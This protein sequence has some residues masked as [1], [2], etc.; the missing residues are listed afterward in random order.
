MHYVSKRQGFLSSPGHRLKAS[1][2]TVLITDIPR[3]LC[4]VEALAALYDDFPGGIRRIW[5]NRNFE[6]LVQKEAAR[7]TF[8]TFLEDAETNLVRR[9]VKQ[10]RKMA[11]RKDQATQTKRNSTSEEGRK[12]CFGNDRNVALGVDPES[13]LGRATGQTANI[14]PADIGAC[15][16]DLGYDLE[17]KAAWTS[18]CHPKQRQKMRIPKGNH[19]SAFKI[20]LIGRLFSAKVDTIYYCRRQLARLNREIEADI[21]RPDSFPQTR[22]AFI[23]FQSQKAAHMACQTTADFMPRQMTNRTV[24][25]SPGDINWANLS[26]TWKGRYLRLVVFLLLFLILILAFGVISVFT[27]VLSRV[28]TLAG[29]TSWLR[30]VEA[31]PSWLLSFI[32]GTL[33]PV[34]QVILLSGPLPIILRA[35]TNSTKGSTTGS[36]G[37]RALQLWYFIFLLFELFIIPTISSGLTTLVQQILHNPTGTSIPRILATNL[38]T[39][40]NYYFSFLIVQSLSISASSILQT[41]RLLNYYVFGSVNTP[42]SVYNKFTWTNRTRIGSNI[43]WYTLFAVVGLVY[44]IIAPLMLIFVIITFS[45]F[46]IVIKNNVLYVVRTGNVDGGGLFFPGAINQ[47]FT[48]LYFMEIC[49]IGLFFLVRDVQ[50]NV[51]CESQGIIMAV[52]LILTVG[53]QIW[54]NM[55]FSSLF[56]YAPLRLEGDHTKRDREYEMER[57]TSKAPNAGHASDTTMDN[58]E[59]ICASHT[60]TE[61]AVRAAASDKE[62]GLASE[63]RAFPQPPRD[64]TG[65][66]FRADDIQIQQRRD[67]QSAKHILARLNRP[68]D[69]TRFVELE[70]HLTQA[71]RRAGN[72][73]VPR[74]KD[75]EWQMMNDPISQIIMQHN[76]ELEDLDIEE[77]DMLISVAFTHPV[78]RAARPS[79]WIPRDELGVSDDEVKRTR[80]LSEDVRIENRGAFF[81]RNMK[82]EVS[83]PPP[84]MSEFAL[85]MAEL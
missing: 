53:Y 60:N 50:G 21:E 70:S 8:E 44:S 7:T 1:S 40:A 48:G 31:L 78:L 61:A 80:E 35:L 41:I 37:E 13:E 18:Y 82:V 22:S 19:Q 49:L 83:K 66:S 71:E 16:R 34:I 63:E 14:A 43:P 17:T 65:A 58:N 68:L 56:T 59:K 6:A 32:Q 54:L 67:G 84:D 5:L 29:S 75:V 15:N 62:Q 12:E 20:P 72:V 2:T 25:I 79:V 11:R 30:W 39:A 28:S 38:P 27:G 24:E 55:S 3:E 74:R 47:L 52:A 46:W 33:P 85:V 45:L 36:Q 4:T 10:E 64:D 81:D 42:D 73:L 76:D 9:A 57:L 23:Q 26:L 69:E 77:R 51:A